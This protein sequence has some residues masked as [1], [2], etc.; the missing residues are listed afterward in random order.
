MS[1]PLTGTSVS[2]APMSRSARLSCP[3]FPAATDRPNDS[4][5]SLPWRPAEAGLQI[6]EFVPIRPFVLPYSTITAPAPG[7]PPALCSGDP[8]RVQREPLRARP[9]QAARCAELDRDRTGGDLTAHGLAGRSD[10]Q[11]CP[12]IA[13]EVAGSQAR[14]PSVARGA[15]PGDPRGVLVEPV[16]ANRRQPVHRA[17]Q[18]DDLAGVA[19]PAGHP[20]GGRQV[21]EAVAIEVARGERLAPP[22]IG[23][24]PRGHTALAVHE[25]QAEVRVQA[26]GRPV[27]DEHLA[28]VAAV[29]GG[30]HG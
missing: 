21:R 4:G 2:G 26:L 29:A 24:A 30:P 23:V 5:L 16:G 13:V 12:P 19:G 1:E 28:D 18:P 7:T 17:V 15:G 8:G 3:R 11:V 20:G 25:P 10:H 9:R 6:C 22:V 14:A 27:H